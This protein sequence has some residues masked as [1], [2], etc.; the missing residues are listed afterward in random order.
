M[1]IREVSALGY[2]KVY[3]LVRSAWLGIVLAMSLAA[4]ALG[5]ESRPAYLEITETAVH[6]YDVLWRTPLLS[7]M[8]LPVVLRFPQ[9][10]RNVTEPSSR[11]FPDSLVER[12]VIETVGGLAGKRIGFVGLQGTIAD[13]L[14]RMQMLDGTFST[15]L[16]R[17]S[18]PWLEIAISSGPLAIAG[19]Y[20][21]HGV[22]H[23]LFGF[24]HLLFVLALILIVRSGRV[25]LLTVTAFTIAHSITLSLATLGLVRLPGP[26]VEAVIALSILLLV[27]EILRMQRGQESLTARW[28]WLVAFT[29]GLLHGFGFAGA[30]TEIGLPQ[31]DVPLALFA[32]NVGVEVGQ[33][34]F[35]GVV[36]GSLALAR[37]I[38]FPLLIERRALSIAT[39]A[40]GILAAFW[41]IERL[42]GFWT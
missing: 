11:E 38:G 33:L 34:V 21:M 40:I 20:L 41:F 31:G 24:D 28:P 18:R 8:P 4:G 2:G 30:L 9:S 23:I 37:R 29:F 1:L 14:V 25:L 35:I 3:A 6:R 32:F 39:Y 22:E 5:H 17:A 16:V 19:A 15:T 26:P 7:G 13:V 27:C 12:R 42:A 36:L 10:T